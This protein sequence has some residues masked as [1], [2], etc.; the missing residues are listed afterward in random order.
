M[1]NTEI[2]EVTDKRTREAIASHIYQ[3]I[4]ALDFEERD[5]VLDCICYLQGME[6]YK[7]KAIEF[8]GSD[9]INDCL[10]DV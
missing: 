10:E 5:S 7:T 1:R 6:D 3:V 8:C 2:K 9:F 4:G